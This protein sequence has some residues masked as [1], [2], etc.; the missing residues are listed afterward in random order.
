MKKK[1]SFFEATL[2][3]GVDC[4]LAEVKEE[5][6]VAVYTFDVEWTDAVCEN[7]GEVKLEWYVPMLGFMYRWSPLC[8][9]SRSISPNWCGRRSSMLASNAPMECIY[10]G[11]GVNS[12]TFAVSECAKNIYF[13]TG[14]VEENGNMHV[15]V[16]MAL[17]QY[18]AKNNMS[19]SVRVDTRKIPMNEAVWAVADWWANDLGMTPANV[20]DA[21]R[22]PAYSFWYS[23]HQNL[24]DHDVEEECKRAK[25]LGFNVCIVDDG[26]QTDDNNRGYAFCGDW[27]P[28]V[29]KMG[30]MAAHVKRVHDIGLKYVLWYS[31]P[32]M[33]HKSEHYAEF[34]HMKLKDD[35]HLETC[36]LDPRY[37]K[38]REYLKGIYI[39]ALREWDLD[40]FKLDFIDQWNDYGTIAPYNEGMDIPS[41]HDAVDAFMTDVISSLKAIKPDILLEFRQCYIGP[42]MRKYGN[43]FRVGDCPNDYTKNRVGVLDLRMHL[44]NSAVHSDM[45][46]WNENESPEYAAIQIIGIMFGVMQYSAKLENISAPMKKMSKFWL[47]FLKEHKKLLTEAPVVPYEPELLYTWAKSTCDNECAVGVYSIDKCVKP[48]AVDKIYIANGVASERVLIELRGSYNVIIKNCYG[49]TIHQFKKDFDGITA[50]EVPVGGLITLER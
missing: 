47:D 23:Y 15:I 19:F 48:D 46:M 21:A 9:S 25:D 38:V 17:K 7:D 39:K 28:A 41:L 32:Y 24:T 26:W 49:D 40:G 20:P 35:S 6:G 11:K 2:S 1:L 42:L 13:G 29:A 31:V 8:W 33:G 50:I 27:K 22:E 43:M 30:D 37:K 4:R 16:K 44:G 36:I 18:T 5:N 34:E 12:Y 45:L 3:D 10:D 14:V